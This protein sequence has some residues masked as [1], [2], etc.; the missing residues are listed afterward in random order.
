MGREQGDFIPLLFFLWPK[1]AVIFIKTKNCSVLLVLCCFSRGCNALK[2]PKSAF[3][4]WEKMKN[5]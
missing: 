4:F 2:W 5:S 3:D 1:T